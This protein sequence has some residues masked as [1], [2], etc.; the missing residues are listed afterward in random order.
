MRIMRVKEVPRGVPDWKR[1]AVCWNDSCGSGQ[2]VAPHRVGVGDGWPYDRGVKEQL[3]GGGKRRRAVKNRNMRHESR[4]PSLDPADCSNFCREP[5]GQ[6]HPEVPRQRS[7][8][9]SVTLDSQ[10]F[11]KNWTIVLP[12]EAYRLTFVRVDLNPPTSEPKGEHI[13]L[14]LHVNAGLTQPDRRAMK[15]ASSA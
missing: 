11:P 15:R 8:S 7:P 1:S 3:G 6:H 9:E 5:P 12:N 14:T 4:P 2:L 10:N 13:H